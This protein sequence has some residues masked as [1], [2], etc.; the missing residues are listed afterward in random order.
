VASAAGGGQEGKGRAEVEVG[1]KRVV[2]GEAYNVMPPKRKPFSRELL[3]QPPP[4]DR[5]EQRK[6]TVA[7]S[8]PSRRAK[9]ILGG[10]ETRVLS[11]HDATQAGERRGGEDSA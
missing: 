9:R 2:T 10:G 4:T 1:S 8:T 11:S 7:G 6:P 3:S 5:D